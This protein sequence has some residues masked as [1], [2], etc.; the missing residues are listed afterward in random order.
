MTQQ[1]EKAC[2]TTT[3][4][5]RKYGMIRNAVSPKYSRHY[6]ISIIIII[7]TIIIIIIIIIIGD[8]PFKMQRAETKK[9]KG[10]QHGGG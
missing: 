6:I 2:L 10:Y 8:T 9:K 4:Y 5:Q 3:P 1:T 7:I